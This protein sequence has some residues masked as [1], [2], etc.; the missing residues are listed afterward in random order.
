M[1]D[2]RLATVIL[3]AVLAIVYAGSIALIVR[4]D[5]HVDETVYYLAADLVRDGRS[6]YD[7]ERAEWDRRAAAAGLDKHQWPYRYPPLTAVLFVPLLPLGGD[8]AALTFEILSAASLAGGAL[9]L[10]AALGGGRRTVAALTLL[11]ACG[12]AYLTLYHGQ[13]NALLFL[14][15][16]LAFWGLS[17]RRDWALA[18]G[19]AVGAALKVVPAGLIVWLFWARRWRQAVLSLAALVLVMLGCLIVV[20]P[21]TTADYGHRAYALS[22]PGVVRNSPGIDTVTA[23]VGRFLL[24]WPGSDDPATTRPVRLVAGLATLAL[25]VATAAAAWPRR[26]QAAAA[27]ADKGRLEFALVL[28]LTLVVGPFTFYHQYVLL[29]IP[30]LLV[31]D[32]L[33]RARRWTLLGVLGLLYLAVDL[34]QIVWMADRDWVLDSGLWRVFA[35]PFLLTM[36]LWACCLAALW[37][38]KW[39]RPSVVATTPDRR[40]APTPVAHLGGEGAVD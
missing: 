31:G 32:R 24:D 15:V 34:Q 39:R 17:Q 18:T 30:L 36:A 6:P 33:W 29:L 26:G 4:H 11:L 23:V 9:L 7:V 5:T 19:L 13:I 12:P 37:R 22:E 2:A 21:D 38:A 3:L 25:I 27:V 8:G 1:R 20:G 35:F 10:G 16:A 40:P 14:A 28:A